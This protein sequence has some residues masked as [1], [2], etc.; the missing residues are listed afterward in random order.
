MYVVRDPYEPTAFR[1]LLR[2]LR[3][4]EPALSPHGTKTGHKTE[5]F[6]NLV[7]GCFGRRRDLDEGT[8]LVGGAKIKSAMSDLATVADYHHALPFGGSGNGL[9]CVTSIQGGAVFD[10]LPSPRG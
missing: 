3:A 5:C 4:S 6:G 7:Y 2:A 8:A 10:A 1:L 9:Q